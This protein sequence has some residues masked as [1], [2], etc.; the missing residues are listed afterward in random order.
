MLSVSHGEITVYS[1]LPAFICS[2]ADHP[3]SFWL[4]SHDSI[5]SHSNISIQG[6]ARPVASFLG[7]NQL[8]DMLDDPY[9]RRI[10]GKPYAHLLQST[11]L[12]HFFTSFQFLRASSLMLII[13]ILT[14]LPSTKRYVHFF[15]VQPLALHLGNQ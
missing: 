5:E 1:I 10:R 14:S 13:N 12:N 7:L 9:R 4:Q 2:Q 11:A 6:P 15:L 8:M 3:I